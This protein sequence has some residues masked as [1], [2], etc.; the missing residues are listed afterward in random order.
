MINSKVLSLSALLK[1][2]KKHPKKKIVFTNGC[3]DILHAG[4]VTYLEKAR[5][6][7]DLLIVAL[8]TDESTRKLKGP[9]RPINTLSDRSKVIAA[10]ESVSYVISFNDETPIK[11]IKKILPHILVKGGDY[12]IKKIVGYQE[13]TDHGGKVITIPFLKG[14][15][16]SNVIKKASSGS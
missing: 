9:T 6:K 4:H 14:R 2:L 8:N 15:S 13:V 11:L 3:F 12:E 10:L 1:T 16:T 7:G 5:S